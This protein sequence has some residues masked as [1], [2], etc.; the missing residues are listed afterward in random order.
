[1]RKKEIENKPTPELL[2][3]ASDLAFCGITKKDL[4]KIFNRDEVIND[5]I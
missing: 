3:L 2:K 1:M 4:D 5:N